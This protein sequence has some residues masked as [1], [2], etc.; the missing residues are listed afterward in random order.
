MLNDYIQFGA[1]QFELMENRGESVKH[2]AFL[3]I[4][5]DFMI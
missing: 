2:F 1:L 3:I 4:G 5:S